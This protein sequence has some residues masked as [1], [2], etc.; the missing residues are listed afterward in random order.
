MVPRVPDYT[1]IHKRINKLDIRIKPNI[2]GSIVLA[3][4]STGIK[5]TNRGDWIAHK[6]GRKR[7]GFLKIMSAWMCPQNRSL[8]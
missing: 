3:V 4:D 2:S 5:V 8:P 1:A 6:W 7:K